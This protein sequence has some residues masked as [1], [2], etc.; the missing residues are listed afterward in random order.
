MNVTKKPGGAG[1]QR[2]GFGLGLIVGLLLGLAVALGVA[3]YVTKVPIPFVDKVPQRSAEQD[4]AEAKANK[5]WNPNAPLSAGHAK[6]RATVASGVV[7]AAP[8][9]SQPAA[10]APTPAVAP[11]VAPVPVAGPAASA[12]TVTAAPNAAAAAAKSEGGGAFVFF[13]QA[14]AFVQANDAE[15]Q[16]AKLAMQ[17]FNAKVYERDNQ[18]RIVYRVRIWPFDAKADADK[19]Q[20]EVQAAGLEA[21]VVRAQR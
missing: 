15:Q 5:D 8:P 14:G 16:R 10:P 11:V 6:A 17:G 19:L 13:V 9:A 2:G 18:G 12:P 1:G 21:A 7:A 3:L 20:A 4:E